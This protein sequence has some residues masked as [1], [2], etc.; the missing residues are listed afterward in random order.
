M[1]APLDYQ[2]R[3]LGDAAATGAKR[4]A[5]TKSAAGAV[6]AVAGAL[7]PAPVGDLL[8]CSGPFRACLPQSGD[9]KARQIVGTL[10]AGAAALVLADAAYRTV[11][12]ARD[13][14]RHPPPGRLVDVGGY[15]LYIECAGEGHPPVVICP[16]LGAG[17]DEWVEVQRLAARETVVCVYDRGGLGWSDPPKKRRTAAR[18]AGELHALLHNAGIA[19]PYVLVGHSMGGLVARVFAHLYPGEVA[20]LALI[21]SSHPEMY[22]RLTPSHL[23]HYPGGILLHIARRRVSPLGLRRLTRDLGFHETSSI[24]WARD[25]RAT[26]SELL[27]IRSICRETAELTGDLGDLPLAVLTASEFGRGDRTRARYQDWVTLQGE[28]AALS[29][30]NTHATAEHGGHHLNR[31]NPELVSEVIAGLVRRVRS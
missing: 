4:Q 2:V 11:G 23:T 10:A 12:E 22:E 30:N 13:R 1:S 9:M 7:D 17:T 5:R 16:A 14:R 18:M 15:Q 27:A 26:D 29:T 28:L 21:D 6:G 20:G 3:L 31:D 8:M 19:A 25:R 24:G